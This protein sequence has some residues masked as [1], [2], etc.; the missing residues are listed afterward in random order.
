MIQ[1]PSRGR[2]ELGRVL[3]C[4]GAGGA[5]REAAKPGRKGLG[6]PAGVS[7]HPGGAGGQCVHV[8]DSVRT[9]P[10][11]APAAGRARFVYVRGRA[12]SACVFPGRVRASCPL[13]R[14]GVPGREGG[15][16]RERPPGEDPGACYQRC[17]P[18][19]EGAQRGNA[20]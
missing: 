12:A 8:R 18:G 13:V 6:G 2:R 15:R 4:C 5:G 11:R 7:V 20:E 9:F 10:G 14:A 3:G 1:G 19:E 17:V 16:C